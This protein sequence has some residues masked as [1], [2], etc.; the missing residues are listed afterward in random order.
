MVLEQEGHPQ[1]FVSSEYT[2]GLVQ[3]VNERM[4]GV[5]SS[6]NKGAAPVAAKGAG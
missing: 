2:L 4:G 5:L 3:A 1:T 6:I